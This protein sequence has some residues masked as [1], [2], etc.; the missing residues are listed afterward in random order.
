[1][2]TMEETAN[3]EHQA[4]GTRPEQAQSSTAG[5]RRTMEI[6]WAESEFF[7]VWLKLARERQES[8]RN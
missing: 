3:L 8:T 6:H 4:C 5:A 1:M 2:K 7:Q